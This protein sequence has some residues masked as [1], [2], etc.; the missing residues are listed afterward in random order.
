MHIYSKF[1]G[2]YGQVVGQVLLTRD[3]TDFPISRE[4]VMNTLKVS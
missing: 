1:F 4:N 3:V 2:E